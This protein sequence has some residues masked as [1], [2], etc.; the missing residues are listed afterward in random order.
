MH[1]SL[2]S[3]SLARDPR[4]ARFE[5]GV[6]VTAISSLVKVLP[7]TNIDHLSLAFN[8]VGD[9]GLGLIAASLKSTKLKTLDL[10]NADINRAGAEALANVLKEDDTD[11][12]TVNLSNNNVGGAVELLLEAA[13]T[14][15][16][17]TQVGDEGTTVSHCRILFLYSR[18]SSLNCKSATDGSR[19]GFSW[20]CTPNGFE[21]AVRPS[22][23]V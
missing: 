13:K 18:C 21:R 9:S 5:G 23:L 17:L 15:S 8:R 2:T 11:L 16:K 20:Q 7:T 12:T 19:A 10:E 4:R 22:T 3:L 1:P 6:S 14:H